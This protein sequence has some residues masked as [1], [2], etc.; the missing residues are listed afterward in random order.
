MYGGGTEMSLS[1]ETKFDPKSPYAAS[2]LFAHEITKIYRD[3][4][5]CLPLMEY[6]LIMNHQEEV[7]LLNKKNFKSS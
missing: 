2:K 3:S 4:T 5:E 6:C 7:K 1:E